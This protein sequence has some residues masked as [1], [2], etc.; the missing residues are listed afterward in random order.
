[1]HWDFA[2][3]LLFFATVVPILGRRRIQQ[4]TRMP[5]TTKFDRLRLYGS[6]VLFQ[7]MAAAIVL[8]RAHAHQ[9]SSRALAI[10][11]PTPLLSA[12]SAVLLGALVLANQLLS[13]R[14]FANHPEEIRGILPQLAVKIFPQDNIERLGFFALVVTVA[15]CE[16]VIF[17]GFAQEVFQSWA[18]DLAVVGVIGSAMLFALAHL[19]QGKRGLISTLVVGLVLSGVRLLTG[20]LMAPMVAHFVADLSAGML[21][22]KRLADALASPR[23]TGEIARDV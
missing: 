11:I 14:R 7:W 13:I 8:W 20:S 10:A 17:R 1:M 5:A 15:I 19:Y 16:E 3:I 4:L 2:V 6:T 18:H 21:I 22:P 12:T 9:L 23:P